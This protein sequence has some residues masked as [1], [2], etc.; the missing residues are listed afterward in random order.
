MFH[1]CLIV[2]DDF[3]DFVLVVDEM[4]MYF[5][6][7]FVFGIV[8]EFEDG[9]WYDAMDDVGLYFLW[10]YIAVELDVDE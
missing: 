5:F 10:V 6:E 2:L 3:F 9:F 8:F 4:R 7:P 1:L